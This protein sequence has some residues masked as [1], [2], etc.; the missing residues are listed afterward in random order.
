MNKQQA[1]DLCRQLA[2]DERLRV[3]VAIDHGASSPMV[4]PYTEDEEAFGLRVCSEG[5][6]PD[7]AVCVLRVV[8]ASEAGGGELDTWAVQEDIEGATFLYI[9]PNTVFQIREGGLL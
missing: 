2:E 8:Q 7:S 9:G 3:G 5:D 1:T 4:I 6:D